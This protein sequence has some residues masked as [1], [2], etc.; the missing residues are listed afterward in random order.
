MLAGMDIA[1]IPG[2]KNNYKITMDHD[3]ESYMEFVERL[4]NESMGA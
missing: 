2:D 4:E 1:I 3:L